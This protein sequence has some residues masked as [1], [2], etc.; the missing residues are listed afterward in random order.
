VFTTWTVLL[1]IMTFS[2]SLLGT[3]LVRSG[4]LTSVHAFASDPTRG[5]FILVFLSLVVGSALL[6]YAIR[7][8]AV[9]RVVQFTA[10]SKETALLINNLLLVVTAASILLGTLYPLIIDALGLGKLSVG[11]PYFNAVFVPLMAPLAL[12]VGVGVLLR[13]KRDE[14]QRLS[15]PLLQLAA[16]CIVVAALVPLAMPFYSAA[17]ALGLALALWTIALTAWAFW[18]RL[19]QWSWLR[20]R[21]VPLS[22]YGMSMA[23]I[24]LA[25]FVIGISFTAQYSIEQDVRLAP[26]EQVTVFDYQI[27][28]TGLSQ[29]QGPNYRADQAHLSL[30]HQGQWLADLAPEKRLYTTQKMPMTEA[31]IDAGIFRDIFVAMGEPLDGQ[32]AWSF[33][34]YYKA[35][36]RWIWMGGVLMAL[37]GVL[38]AC[39]SRYRHEAKRLRGVDA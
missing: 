36:I 14:W 2:L 25:V 21:Q 13:W 34:I 31:A 33:R 15:K 38:S 22:F 32:G 9:K 8:P 17:A 4:V 39:D 3:F 37:G 18:Q 30:Q 6:L 35:C 24:G 26:G 11:P 12:V 10:L 20:L 16:G 23:H 7:A 19:Q 27:K 5:L 1:A 28:F 29:A